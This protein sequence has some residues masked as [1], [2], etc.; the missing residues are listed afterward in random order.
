VDLETQGDTL[1]LKETQHLD[2]Q[3][4]QLTFKLL[5]EAVEQL[6]PDH[7]LHHTEVD[8]EELELEHKLHHHLLGRLVDHSDTSQAEAVD[9]DHLQKDVEVSEGAETVTLE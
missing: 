5:G 1:H 8:P 9:Q 3:Q 2:H 4:H 7:L 6:L